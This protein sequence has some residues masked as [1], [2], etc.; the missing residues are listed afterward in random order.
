MTDKDLSRYFIGLKEENWVTLPF[1]YIAI[2][3]I[4]CY[5][6]LG[7]ITYDDAYHE[8]LG[9]YYVDAKGCYEGS[10]SL[11]GSD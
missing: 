4:I 10:Y 8:C 6:S 9:A 3:L 11:F 5:T 7:R 2:G 1:F